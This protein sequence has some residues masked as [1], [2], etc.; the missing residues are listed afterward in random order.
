MSQATLQF[1]DFV[2][3]ELSPR[4]ARRA[5]SGEFLVCQPVRDEAG[6]VSLDLNLPDSVKRQML[7]AVKHGRYIRIFS[8]AR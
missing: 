6:N 3:S 2:I 8:P 5:G 1:K 4:T 7:E